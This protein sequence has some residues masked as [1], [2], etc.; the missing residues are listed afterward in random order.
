LMS[1]WKSS[2]KSARAREH[3]R[4]YLAAGVMGSSSL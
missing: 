1:D 3:I 2:I 4:N